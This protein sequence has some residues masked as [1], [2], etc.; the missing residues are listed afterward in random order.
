MRTRNIKIN[1]YLNENE[2]KILEEK[3]S[4]MELSQSD[5]LRMLIQDYSEKK[6]LDKDI[7]EFIVSLSNVYSNLSELS[8]KLNRLCY[9]DFVDFLNEQIFNIKNAINQIKKM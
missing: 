9:Y 6:I 5:F 8:N 4:K 1:V 3:S 7:D 2:K